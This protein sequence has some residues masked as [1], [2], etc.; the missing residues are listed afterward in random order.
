VR[1]V[2]SRP[3]GVELARALV[4]TTW[5]APLAAELGF[6][7]GAVRLLGDRLRRAELQPLDPARAVL[8]ALMSY[9]R[10]GLDVVLDPMQVRAT[11]PLWKALGVEP[12]P[13]GFRLAY[14]PSRHAAM[15]A[16][17][18]IPELTYAAEKK[19]PDLRVMVMANVQ[20]EHVICGLLSV[21]RVAALPGLVEALVVR[22]RSLKV[23]LEIAN[24]RELHTGAA[25]RNVPRALLWHPSAVPV[26]ALRKFAHVRFVDRGEL[27]AMAGRGS[28][29]RPEVR[30]L[31]ALYLA[32]LTTT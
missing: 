19:P 31:A 21:P 16:D 14:D 24:R 26:S 32:S 9:R 11:L 28:R 25:N 30:Q 23:L 5:R 4:L 6:L 7:G 18:G 17:D 29:A 27:A 8:L 10:N 12:Q 2:G 15:V 3:E 22:T 1:E 20:N 13:G